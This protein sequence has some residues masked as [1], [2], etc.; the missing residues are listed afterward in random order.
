M[1]SDYWMVCITTRIWQSLIPHAL[2]LLDGL[3]YNKNLTIIDP[4]CPLITGWFVL[5]QE[6]DNHWSHMPSDYW[7]VCITTRIWQSLIPHALWLR[8]GLGDNGSPWIIDPTC[9][10]NSR[11]INL[12][13]FARNICQI[14][15]RLLSCTIK[16]E[17][18]PRCPP[19]PPLPPL[20][21][22]L[23]V[24]LQCFFM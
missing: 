10:R 9:H 17:A 8:D 23:H 14:F 5:Q 16:Q 21:Q 2:L 22:N 20:P 3:Y 12:L 11:F 1:P 15:S 6:F 24:L 7:M 19:P 18:L 13:P 4:T